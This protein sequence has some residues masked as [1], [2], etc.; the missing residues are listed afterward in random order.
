[1]VTY[2]P[3]IHTMAPPYHTTLLPYTIAFTQHVHPNLYLR[4]HLRPTNSKQ[5]VQHQFLTVL[6]TRNDRACKCTREL[7][8]QYH[9]MPYHTLFL[10]YHTT[11]TYH[12]HS[13]VL[14]TGRQKLD[15]A[16]IGC[17]ALSVLVTSHHRTNSRGTTGAM[18]YAPIRFGS[19]W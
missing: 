5:S 10:A 13:A 9:T 1:M 18:G 16:A 3:T 14:I 17:F 11:P 8:V 7:R 12:S 15:S 19:L 6:S 2:L 4:G